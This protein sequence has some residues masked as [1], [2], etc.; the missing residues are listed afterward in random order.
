MKCWH[1]KAEIST[2]LTGSQTSKVTSKR[3][4]SV[5]NMNFCFGLF[6]SRLCSRPYARDTVNNFPNC[7]CWGKCQ[8]CCSLIQKPNGRVCKRLKRVFL[9]GVCLALFL[10]CIYS[11]SSLACPRWKP[12]QSGLFQWPVCPLCWGGGIGI[13]SDLCSSTSAEHLSTCLTCS[14]SGFQ[15]C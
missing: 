1:F 9:P 13:A 4:N 12:G 11:R 5:Y 2:K 6:F 7:L 15:V 10:N 8:L 14:P 3:E